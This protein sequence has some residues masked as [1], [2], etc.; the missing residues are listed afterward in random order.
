MWSRNQW[1]LTAMCFEVGARWGEVATVMAPWLSS[2]TVLLV[3]MERSDGRLRTSMTS[4]TRSQS[5]RRSCRDCDNVTYLAWRVE[6]AIL[7]W[8]LETHCS[9]QF[10]KVIKNPVQDLAQIG[11]WGRSA[12]QRPAKSTS[13]KQLT[14]KSE[15]VLKSNHHHWFLLGIDRCTKQLPHD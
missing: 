4:L 15:E 2:K 12:P 3:T 14:T 8:S 9:G 6:R 10:A 11:S 13:T 7:V 1:Y 5:G